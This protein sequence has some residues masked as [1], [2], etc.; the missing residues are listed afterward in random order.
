MAQQEYSPWPIVSLDENWS[1]DLKDTEQ[2]PF[3]GAAVQSFIK[4]YLRDMLASGTMENN[5]INFYNADGE[6]VFQVPIS[7][8]IYY[9]TLSSTLP[10]YI[11]DTLPSYPV[12]FS[13]LSEQSPIGSQERT[14]VIEGS[15]SYT[16]S[17]DSGSGY[18]PVS[19]GTILSGST[20]SVTIDVR[21]FLSS[22]LNSLKMVMTGATSNKTSFLTQNVNLTSFY[23]NS[24][25]SYHLP[26]LGAE[27]YYLNNLYFYGAF[28]KTL[29]VTLTKGSFTST[30]SVTFP[31]TVNYQDSPYRLLLSDLFQLPESGVYSLSF[32][33]T[34]AGQSTAHYSYNIIYVA[35]GEEGL[36]YLTAINNVSSSVV[37]YSETQ[38]FDIIGYGRA[39]VTV[40]QFLAHDSIIYPLATRTVNLLP[41]LP[42]PFLVALSEDLE[43]QS[44]DYTASVSI[45][46][47]NSVSAT[48]P[49][50]LS[51]SYIPTPGY[52][53]YLKPSSQSNADPN[54]NTFFNQ[55]TGTY[56][57]VTFTNFAF[58]N[59]GW[60]TLHNRSCLLIRSGSSITTDLIPFGSLVA[61]GCSFEL[62]FSVENISN[63]S[64]SLFSFL[65][66]QGTI[67]LGLECTNSTLGV[68]CE[69]SQDS[70]HQSFSVPPSEPIHLTVSILP[71]YKQ[72]NY[73]LCQLY[74]NGVPIVNFQFA[75]GSSFGSA[76]LTF[77]PTNSDLAIYLMRLY[78]SALD[79]NQ[80]YNNLINAAS[81]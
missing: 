68:Y 65:T 30:Q 17:V 38:A 11:L 57:P 43:T 12:T 25:F 54:R 76:S 10:T 74:L 13:Y 80:V 41:N 69:A 60:S 24:S 29:L 16:L 37:N 48:I 9:L 67:K 40:Q 62:V 21:P 73:N 5:N 61:N 45:L 28:N 53:F 3:S 47:G 23:L 1:K 81:N 79:S 31:S 22:G 58:C 46:S 77:N 34:G 26:W 75:T 52:S 2:R 64:S 27:S 49:V 59:D 66:T 39:S 51:E 63:Y 8:T 50:D 36:V 71:R 19:S 55:A 78:P 7:S 72:S 6:V 70:V 33:M 42:T 56:H 4:S 32:Y 15:V 18:L 44:A 35:P 14:P 20:G